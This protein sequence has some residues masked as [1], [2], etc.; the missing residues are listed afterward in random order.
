LLEDSLAAMGAVIVLPV[1]R[2]TK[3]ANWYGQMRRVDPRLLGELEQL[4]TQIAQQYAA[5]AT[6]TAMPAA[7]AQVYAVTQLLDRAVMTSTQRDRLASIGADA[8]AMEGVLALNMSAPDEARDAFDLALDLARDARDP[9][10]EALVTAAE[11]ILWSP[12]S[13][14]ERATGDPKQAV[15]AMAHACALGRHAP[16]LNRVWLHVFHAR[17]LAAAR[18][19]VGSARARELAFA[20]LDDLGSNDPGWGFFSLHGEFAGFRDGRIHAFEGKARLLLGQ[21]ADAIGPLQQ[22]IDTS[23]MPIKQSI[24]GEDLMRAWTGAG[25]PE[26]ACAAANAAL[27]GV[28]ATG[29]TLSVETVRDIRSTFPPD[30]SHLDCVRELDDRLRAHA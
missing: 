1:D 16:T 3:W 10:L 11:T 18:D 22:A 29:F 24:W 23:T 20:T 30:W 17:D 4:S 27:E 15:T 5:G 8:A 7:K 28:D 21:H 26:P 6:A 14:W 13:L 2:L 12:G 25:E 9:R 19:A